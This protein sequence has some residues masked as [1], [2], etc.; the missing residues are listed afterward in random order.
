MDKYLKYYHKASVVFKYGTQNWTQDSF[1]HIPR[2]QAS[3]WSESH[4][5][6]SYRLVFFEKYFLNFLQ[7]HNMSIQ[8]SARAILYGSMTEAC[9]MATCDEYAMWTISELILN[10]E[11][12]TFTILEVK[13]R[14][15][16]SSS[17]RGIG[18]KSIGAVGED[19]KIEVV[20]DLME[21]STL[22]FSHQFMDTNRRIIFGSDKKK[23]KSLAAS[24]GESI[25]LPLGKDT[26]RD[27]S[28]E[29]ESYLQ[30]MES[31][32]HREEPILADTPRANRTDID[33]V[34]KVFFKILKRNIETLKNL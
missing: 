19:G 18:H 22:S 12:G 34:I 2:P 9:G 15:S 25:E 27:L 3:I 8:L 11:P 33:E 6:Q 23:W 1:P 16:L 32:R 14:E 26:L 30:E 31:C 24:L 17:V 10:N 13:P 28:T 21:M 29:L 7:I 20:I 5:Y 4:H